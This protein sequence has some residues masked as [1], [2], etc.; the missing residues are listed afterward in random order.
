MQETE[1]V[2]I[3]NEANNYLQRRTYRPTAIFSADE[4][5]QKISSLANSYKSSVNV[6]PTGDNYFEDLDSEQLI[7]DIKHHISLANTNYVDYGE[8]SQ[9]EN[10][11]LGAALIGH[12]M[13]STDT[14]SPY[15]KTN[16]ENLSSQIAP[17]FKENIAPHH[18][19]TYGG[20]LTDLKNNPGIL[21]TV[22]HMHKSHSNIF[23][24]LHH[25]NHSDPN[26]VLSN[27]IFCKHNHEL[28]YH[29][30]NAYFKRQ[31]QQVNR[32]TTP[33]YA[34]DRE[35][36]HTWNISNHHKVMQQLRENGDYKL[37][38]ELHKKFTRSFQ[39]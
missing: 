4:Y 5:V 13:H 35:I 19:T 1:L 18:Y 16:F 6:P 39:K 36:T 22:H 20:T 17:E 25:R 30:K 29:Y 26:A 34:H 37:R 31:H 7:N 27:L 10:L 32:I 24:E 28:A 15:F 3:F 21:N 33:C 14:H 23:N 12:I 38:D 9:E 11:Q 8:Y 2:A